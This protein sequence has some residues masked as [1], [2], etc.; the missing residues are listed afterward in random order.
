MITQTATEAH[1]SNTDGYGASVVRMR[2]T[3]ERGAREW[4][5]TL[6][7]PGLGMRETWF[8]PYGTG[9]F[10]PMHNEDPRGV[11]ETLASFLGAWDEAQR[12][13]GSENRD[14]FPRECEPFLAVAE[15]F[16]ADVSGS[17]F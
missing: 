9:I 10:A 5:I 15:E 6:A 8:S 11:L 3:D 17:E 4:R 7:W 13:E 16:S 2:H 1:W 12:Y 14:L